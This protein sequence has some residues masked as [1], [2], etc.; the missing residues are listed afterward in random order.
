M[1]TLDNCHNNTCTLAV[2]SNRK[3]TREQL[4]NFSVRNGQCDR[5]LILS[6]PVGRVL[7]FSVGE[8]DSVPVQCAGC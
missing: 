6:V 7:K 4:R 2:L 5:V 8:M 3:N 1:V